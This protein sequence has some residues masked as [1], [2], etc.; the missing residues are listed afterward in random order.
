MAGRGALGLGGGGGR[1]AAGGVIGSCLYCASRLLGA[2]SA[3]PAIKSRG[4]WAARPGEARSILDAIAP[5]SLQF[6]G[7][8]NAPGV[9]GEE[10][11]GPFRRHREG[12]PGAR[13]GV[14]SI[15][16]ARK[17]GGWAAPFAAGLPILDGGSDALDDEC[18]PV[19]G[20]AQAASAPCPGRPIREEAGRSGQ[21]EGGRPRMPAEGGRADGH[22]L[23]G[24]G[25]AGQ[26]AA[27]PK[28]AAPARCARRTRRSWTAEGLS[29]AGGG[30][31]ERRPPAGRRLRGAGFGGCHRMESPA[32]AL[33]RR[34]A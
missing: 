3:A 1:R 19:Q 31:P 4:G 27:P 30:P 13:N 24:G 32:R 9:D 11:S 29:G 14:L 10:M 12:W 16:K 2:T 28:D 25:R 26:R 7:V 20:D 5:P 33:L 17:G 34:G 21:P 23:P 6:R 15:A 18:A 8:Y 22:A